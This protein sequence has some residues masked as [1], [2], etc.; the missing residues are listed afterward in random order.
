M[1]EL[2]EGIESTIISLMRYDLN[3]YPKQAQELANK[4]MV[5]FP[6]II[7]C[8]NDP[9]MQDKREDAMYWPGQLERI[10]AAFDRGDAFEVTDVLYNETR[11]NLMELKAILTQRGLI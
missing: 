11:A 7:D 6:A 9:L 1:D 5:I 3:E 2:I 10:L 8:Y 4:M